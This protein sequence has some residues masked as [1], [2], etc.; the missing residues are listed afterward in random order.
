MIEKFSN[1]EGH[2]VIFDRNPNASWDEKIYQR[3]EKLNGK[4]ITVWGV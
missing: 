2:F 3:N 1:T 4:T